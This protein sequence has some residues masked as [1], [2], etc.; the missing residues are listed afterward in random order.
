[1]KQIEWAIGVDPQ[2]VEASVQPSL[3]KELSELLIVRYGE[4]TKVSEPAAAG[5]YGRLVG[6]FG[7]FH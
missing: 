7:S 6:S 5:S 4:V 3:V 2:V 1:M